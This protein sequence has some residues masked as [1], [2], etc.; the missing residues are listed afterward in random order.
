MQ[1]G[2]HVSH[3]LKTDKGIFPLKCIEKCLDMIKGH[4]RNKRTKD[5]KS[6]QITWTETKRI[7]LAEYCRHYLDY[8]ALVL[9]KSSTTR[10][11]GTI[12]LEPV[13]SNINC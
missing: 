5:R 6:T 1:I 9:K 8:I 3:V 12:I 13:N 4:V 11:F 2:T 7:V 10:N